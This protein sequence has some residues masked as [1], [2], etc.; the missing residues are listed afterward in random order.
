MYVYDIYVYILIC[1]YMCIYVVCIYICNPQSELPILYLVM[2]YY[3]SDI[4][5]VIFHLENI[6][7]LLI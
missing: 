7:Y 5:I 4:F 6:Q 1:V 2:I 3:I